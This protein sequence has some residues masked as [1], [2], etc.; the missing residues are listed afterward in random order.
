[1]T[2]DGR[3]NAVDL[4]F[5]I[6][7]GEILLH[8]IG[9]RPSILI[10][11]RLG[12]IAFA[13]IILPILS[14][15]LHLLFNFTDNGIFSPDLEA[16]DQASLIVH[17]QQRTN[18]EQR[19]KP[20]GSLGDPSSLHIEAEVGGEKPM[21]HIQPVFF[22]PPGQ[23]FHFHALIPQIGQ[24]IHQKAISRGSSQRIHNED[25]PIREFLR[26]LL[27]RHMGGI[28]GARNSRRQ[29]HMKDIL[30]RLQKGSKIGRIFFR[31]DLGCFG[32][33][34]I[35]HGLIETVKRNGL[36]QIIGIA[37]SIQGIVKADIL[38]IPALQVLHRKIH[39]GAATQHK[40]THKQ[41]SFPKQP[42]RLS[43]NFIIIY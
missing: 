9:Y 6:E 42:L 1:M 38:N 24:F 2:A 33:R 15:F 39:C 35:G 25:L 18:V 19:T 28:D 27:L 40:I 34:P 7:M 12:D 13:I 5:A 32:L 11:S 14:K 17:I 20:T 21:V 30:S 3:A 41:D 37:L 8:Q 4:H 36:P 26:Q 31:I 10:A 16:G 22:G 43:H 23:L 29:R